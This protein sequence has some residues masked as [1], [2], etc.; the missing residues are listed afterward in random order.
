MFYLHILNA[1]NTKHSLPPS[2]L[3]AVCS[4]ILIHFFLK[5]FKVVL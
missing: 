5:I 3:S 2:Q 1:M 4:T